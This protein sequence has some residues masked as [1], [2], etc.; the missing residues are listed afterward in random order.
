[1]TRELF[2]KNF[3][4]GT[5]LQISGNLIYNGLYIFDEMESFHFEEEIFEFLYNIAVGLERLMKIVIILTTHDKTNEKQDSFEERIKTHNHKKLMEM[6]RKYHK[7][8][9]GEQHFDFLNLLENFYHNMRY[10][11]FSLENVRNYDKEKKY[12]ESFLSKHLEVKINHEKSIFITNPNNF[13][14]KKKI[15]KL[16]GKISTQLYNIIKKESYRLNIYTYEIRFNSKAHK[17]F[18]REEFD[19]NKEHTYEKEMLIF[20]MNVN[21]QHEIKEIIQNIEPL[22]FDNGLIPEY[23]KH[24][25]SRLKKLEA[26][27]E[28]EALY[29]DLENNLKSSRQE[30][31]RFLDDEPDIFE[32]EKEIPDKKQFEEMIDIADAKRRNIIIS[33][34]V[35][36]CDF[37]GKIMSEELYLIDGKTK[38]GPWAWM[39]TDCFNEK[40][41]GIK[42]GT[43]QLYKK[44]ANKWLLVAG[45][46]AENDDLN[47]DI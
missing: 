9:L 26:F 12:F 4:L 25:K 5:E 2:W 43:G 10:D 39:C 6:V 18:I 35:E 47:L 28:M 29:E 15:G 21:T 30:V 38:Q 33:N 24:F 23:I 40:G 31:F 17:I 20:L 1:M 41:I 16:I 34:D 36:Y 42:W 3:N 27:D 46:D 32:L 11:R 37:C 14:I 45:Y 22:N 7:V 13:I 44:I 8:N 19:F